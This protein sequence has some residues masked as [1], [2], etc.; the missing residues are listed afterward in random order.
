M[1]VHKRR[2]VVPTLT[3]SRALRSVRSRRVARHRE[4]W[5]NHAAA[6]LANAVT[7]V[8]W[9]I[10]PG[11]VLKASHQQK[12]QDNGEIPEGLTGL[13]RAGAPE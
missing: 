12:Q 8:L 1:M 10:K 4:R 2:E 5:Y 7:V 11:T 6:S 9:A 3:Q 13:H